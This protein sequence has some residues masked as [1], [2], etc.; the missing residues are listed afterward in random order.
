MGLFL[1]LCRGSCRPRAVRGEQVLP[2]ADA[3]LLGI[4]G[5]GNGPVAIPFTGHRQVNDRSDHGLPTRFPDE[6][7]GRAKGGLLLLSLR[8]KHP[9]QTRFGPPGFSQ[10]EVEQ[11]RD[12]LQRA[13]FRN[14]RKVVR[15]AG[16]EVTFL[17]AER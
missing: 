10:G 8:M 11:V 3:R 7:D 13:E 16:R 1:R 14:I 6:E 5:V 17:M 9:R 15:E 12:M 4:Q 2:Q